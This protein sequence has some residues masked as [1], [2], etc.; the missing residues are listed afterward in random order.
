MKQGNTSYTSFHLG[1]VTVQEGFT[2]KK[3]KKAKSR[4]DD[5]LELAHKKNGRLYFVPGD[6]DWNNSKK[7]GY[8]TVLSLEKYLEDE[9]KYKNVL[10]PENGCPGPE[11][12][13]LDSMI[14]IIAINTPWFIYPH[15][16]PAIT[17]TACSNLTNDEFFE[18]L[19]EAIDE[20]EHRQIII[21]G[22]HPIV[23]FGEY[24]GRIPF[25]KHIFPL[26]DK[27]PD[28]RV[29]LPILGSAYASYR[30][31][32]GTPNDMSY[33]KYGEYIQRMK[34]VIDQY[35]GLI[36][37]SAHDYNLQVNTLDGNYQVISGSLLQAGKVFHDAQ[38]KMASNK[39]GFSKIILYEN[40]DVYVAFF[41]LSKDRVSEISRVKLF[42]H[43][44]NHAS[45][46]QLLTK[47]D[48]LTPL[49]TAT[50][51]GANYKQK[52]ILKPVMGSLYRTEW[53]TQVTIPLLPIDTLFG[54]LIA[55]E[56]GGGLQTHSLKF[57][58]NLGKEYVFRSV[59]KDPSKAFEKDLR[60]TVVMDFI[61]DM[62]ATQHPYGALPVSYMLDK[63]SILHARPKLY[64]MPRHINLGEFN[65]DFEGVF[66][67]L[68]DKPSDPTDLLA[69]FAD[70]DNITKSTSL[71]R[72]LY[73]DSD[74]QVEAE[75]YAKVR[76]FDM[77]I[78][79][80]DRHQDNIKWAGYKKDGEWIYRPIPRDRDHSF[81]K[82]DGLF[83]WF[84][85]RE[86]AL[87]HTENFG[88]KF[89]GLQSL[90][91][92]ALH[93]D[94]ALLSG[95]DQKDWELA[96]DYIVNQITDDV[97]DS[98]MTTF[99]KEL[100][101]NPVIGDK[102]KSRR[103]RLK[104]AVV[105]NYKLLSKEV[106]VIGTNDQ[107]YIT[108]HRL[109]NGN[110]EVKM[111]N[112]KKKDKKGKLLYDRTF[113]YKETKE[114]RIYSLGGD[115]LIEL[116]GDV[117]KSI[118][119]R[120]VGGYGEDEV[121]DESSV[122][123]IKNYT[124]V[125][126]HHKLT[127]K[128]ENG[129]V[130]FTEL[131]STD[132]YLYNRSDYK[133]DDYAPLAFVGYNKDDNL[134][135]TGG[136]TFTKHGFLGDEFKSKHKIE[137]TYASRESLIG[138]YESIW[139][140]KIGEFDL[141]AKVS[142]ATRYPLYDFYGLGNTTQKDK[143][144]KSNDFYEISYRG[145]SNRFFLQ[146]RF[147]QRSSFRIGSQLEYFH[148]SLEEN[149]I[150]TLEKN[151]NLIGNNAVFRGGFTEL[152]IDFRDKTTFPERGMRLWGSY[153]F[154]DKKE[155]PIHLVKGFWEH[156]STI[157]FKT[158]LTL[159]FKI[160]GEKATGEELPFYKLPN[161]GQGNALRGFLKNRFTGTSSLY[162][163]SDLRLH[164][165]KI[166]TIIAPLHYGLLGLFD[167]GRVWYTKETNSNQ[168]HIGT[169]GGVYIAPLST[170]YTFKLLLT[171]SEEEK[172]L[173]LVGLGLAL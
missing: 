50:V 56:K 137:A 117:D 154:L 94:R 38:N 113:I 48:T 71:F 138:K 61:Q 96:A 91:Y 70:S 106:D 140:K 158:P 116:S 136:V 109:V 62:I 6:H 148:T 49:N 32:V 78:G 40:G 17:S 103:K 123:G 127:I 73:K 72:K 67:L 112:K 79:D 74:T 57:Q 124:K 46:L 168:W 90:N 104:A 26:S 134:I 151:E 92:K 89:T 93:L 39:K 135:L 129:E 98:A 76:V 43:H 37:A 159:G 54:G 108:I 68:E 149:S 31:N 164:L 12:L 34:G 166:R 42:N 105:Q 22:H 99:P 172:F 11:V 173:I 14:R 25:K 64:V 36:Y 58:N 142:A 66:G 102:L 3:K 60:N 155:G 146:Y 1:D 63:T 23:S 162:F 87:K 122:R 160:G 59:N 84:L 101:S 13:D 2:K 128:S 165:G 21:L 157:H 24:G 45:P 111:F 169:G 163:N 125:Y 8:E 139:R 120:I 35:H 115:D 88:Y 53:S 150:L 85:D 97:I 9:I 121:K 171:H 95:L 18:D 19:E 100:T 16:K 51:G 83:C 107:E 27:N 153:E 75:E 5:L 55:Y 144:L 69:G 10:L 130:K 4:I 65:D 118:L 86:W 145:V 44:F 143:E 33:P 82:R 52:P 110:V 133:E 167:A 152:S 47:T 114:I 80:W 141:G 30:Q 170:D 81:S 41:Q 20:A 28:N 147:F 77:L 29:P 126:D 119:I 131:K 15:K 156:Y 161:L 7:G 132:T